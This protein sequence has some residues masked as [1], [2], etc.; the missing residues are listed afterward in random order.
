MTTG[1]HPPTLK[2]ST[3][4]SVTDPARPRDF[5]LTSFSGVAFVL[6]CF[7]LLCFVFRIRAFF[8]AAAFRSISCPSICRRPESHT[9]FFFL[10]MSLFPSIFLYHVRFLFV[11]RVRRTFFPSEWCFLPQSTECGRCYAF[12]GAWLRPGEG[13]GWLAA[14]TMPNSLYRMPVVYLFLACVFYLLV[15]FSLSFLFV[16]VFLF[17]SLKLGDEKSCVTFLLCDPGW[18]VY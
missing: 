14:G 5:P 3:T 7:A 18:Y 13:I 11:W 2:H 9:C 6:F 17:L 1:H 15:P 10:E 8:E 4:S 12:V 16:C